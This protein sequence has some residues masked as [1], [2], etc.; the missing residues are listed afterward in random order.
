[1]TLIR[2]FGA[3]GPFYVTQIALILLIFRLRRWRPATFS[4]TSKNSKDSNFAAAQRAACGLFSFH[5]E[6]TEISFRL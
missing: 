6:S 5:T 2:S 4:F 3:C 1:M